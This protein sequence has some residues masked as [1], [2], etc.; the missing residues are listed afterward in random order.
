MEI[1][2]KFYLPNAETLHRLQEMELLAGYTL[3]PPERTLVHDTYLDTE[4]WQVMAAGYACRRRTKGTQLIFTL[5]GLSDPGDAIHQ[6]EELETI[7]PSDRSPAEWPPS[8]ARD[9]LIDLIGDAPLT[10]LF[11]IDQTRHVRWVMAGERIVAEWSLDQA[12]LKAHGEEQTCFELEI[13][14]VD[15]G[16]REDLEILS[17]FLRDQWG[18]VPET[19]SKFERALTLNTAPRNLGPPLSAPGILPSDDMA[20]AARKILLFQFQRMVLNEP[21]T[22]IGRDIEALHDMRVATRRMRAAFRVFG[23]YVDAKA[24][25]PFLDG[26]RQTGRALG[27]VRDLDV[28]WEKTED[29]LKKLPPERQSELAPLRTAWSTERQHAR[30]R[31]LAYLSTSEYEKFKEAFGDFLTTPGAGARPALGKKGRVRPRRLRHV[32]PAI[33]YAEVAAVQAYDGWVTAPEVP[34]E[35]LHRLRIA[36]KHLRYTLEF[37]REVLGP[38]TKT[39]INRIKG[40]QDHLGAIQDAVVASDVLWHFLESGRWM[41]DEEGKESPALIEAPG[42]RTYLVTKQSELDALQD[43]FPQV[44]EWFQGSE[45]NQMIASSLAVLYE[46]KG[47]CNMPKPR[48]VVLVGPPASGKGTQAVRLQEALKLPHV[49][50]GDLFRENF[51]N[52]TE[53]GRKAKEYM[54]RGELVPDDVTIAMVLDRLSRPDCALGALLD[55]FPRTLAQAEALDA[56]LAEEGHTISAVPYVAVPDDVLIER[57]SGRRLCRTCGKSYHI[58]FNPPETPGVCDVDGGELYQRDDDKPETVRTRLQVY[59]DQTSPL[60]DYYRNKSVLMEIDGDQSIDAVTD[61]LL[62]ALA[63]VKEG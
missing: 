9:R 43:S 49:A 52:E 36:A 30:E 63:D 41:A 47:E 58:K 50:S 60:I 2:A 44:W 48:Y 6:R 25:A 16:T 22:L 7:A 12:T 24:T 61:D 40:L 23:D 19:R 28:F 62:S 39:L 51:K 46:E 26:L 34:P 15:Q 4:N 56:A 3:S 59:R 33:V 10:A 20:E 14:R 55:G 29:Y 42:V 18:L 37:F 54:D 5:K 8:A 38:K 53:L 27:T 57:V 21:G 17:A 13:E 1:E 45:L 31:M 32:L 35:R 11:Q